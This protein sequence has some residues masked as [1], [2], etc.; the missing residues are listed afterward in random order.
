M[1]TSA[2]TR[3]ELWQC[4]G[5]EL[6]I[7]LLAEEQWRRAALDALSVWLQEDTPRIEPKLLVKR[8]VQAMAGTFRGQG[9]GQERL[10]RPLKDMLQCSPKLSAA[11]G[12]Q[13]RTASGPVQLAILPAA[14]KRSSLLVAELAVLL[15]G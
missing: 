1:H 4:Q 12:T 3:A 14:T 7:E 15:L 13:V 6:F 10:L 8:N 11:C 9:A 5:L 2:K